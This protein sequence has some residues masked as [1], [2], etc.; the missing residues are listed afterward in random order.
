[1]AENGASAVGLGLTNF[2]SAPLT[3]KFQLPA[4]ALSIHVTARSKHPFLQHS[5]GT[6]Q[7]RQPKSYFDV[8]AVQRLSCL[9]CSASYGEK[10]VGH[11]HKSLQRIQFKAILRVLGT[12]HTMPIVPHERNG[13]SLDPHGPSLD[14]LLLL[15][16]RLLERNLQKQYN[17]SVVENHSYIGQRIG[18]TFYQSPVKLI[19]V[20]LKRH[21]DATN[22]RNWRGDQSSESIVKWKSGPR[23]GRWNEKR[24][25]LDLCP[26]WIEWWIGRLL[27]TLDTDRT[28]TDTFNL[29]SR[30]FG[31]PISIRVSAI[32]YG[33]LRLGA[34]H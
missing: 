18:L 19:Q 29:L 6:K 12:N 1:M 8:H 7:T 27:L 3:R 17:A 26:W 16:F 4:A 32:F 2:D 13:T 34:R 33:N 11:V 10:E 22:E 20:L 5:G 9:S 25:L 31:S 24:V 21:N 15:H 14:A 23:N 30:P 28:Y